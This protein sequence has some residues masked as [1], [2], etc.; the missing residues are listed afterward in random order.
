MSE[1]EAEPSGIG[2]ALGGDRG[3]FGPMIGLLVTMV[4]GWAGCA[5]RALAASMLAKD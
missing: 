1:G 5:I 4:G 2:R 3:I